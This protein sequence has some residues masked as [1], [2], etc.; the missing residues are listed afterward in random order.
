MKTRMWSFW[1]TCTSIRASSEVNDIWPLVSMALLG[2]ILP[3]RH[4]CSTT[5]STDFQIQDSGHVSEWDAHRSGDLFIFKRIYRKQQQSFIRMVEF[6]PPHHVRYISRLRRRY[7][8]SVPVEVVLK[9]HA[10][11]LTSAMVLFGSTRGG[12]SGSWSILRD[13][14]FLGHLHNHVGSY[15]HPS[16]PGKRHSLAVLG[17]STVLRS[18]CKP[19]PST[20][21]RFTSRA[22]IYMALTCRPSATGVVGLS[23]QLPAILPAPTI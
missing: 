19:N 1:K 16:C 14:A 4:M 8:P 13:D 3:V 15:Q 18:H 12:S 5:S 2:V 6:M 22:K 7:I 20:I 9:E 23:M 17:S 10:Y 11:Y 21:M